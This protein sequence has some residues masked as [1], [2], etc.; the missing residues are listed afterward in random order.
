MP[1]PHNLESWLDEHRQ[2][3]KVCLENSLILPAV[4]LIYIVIDSLG[5]LARPT[6]QISTGPDFETWVRDYLLDGY[7]GLAGTSEKV[8]HDLYGARCAV[9]HRMTAEANLTA[10]PDPARRAREVYYQRH[11]GEGRIPVQ[12]ANTPEPA[13]L[14]D[15]DSLAVS[16][17]QAIERFRRAIN[18]DPALAE[19]VGRRSTHY[20]HVTHAVSL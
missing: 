15:P 12:S 20:F 7:D 11:T 19:R 13:L 1:V 8:A 14:I 3:I 2:A 9:L 18:I 17:A 10:D 5:F 4:V 16:L 6:D